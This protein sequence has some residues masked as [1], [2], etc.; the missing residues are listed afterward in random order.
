MIFLK[1][2][3]I[4]CKNS[5]TS[6]LQSFIYSFSIFS[7]IFIE[8][9]NSVVLDIFCNSIYSPKINIFKGRNFVNSSI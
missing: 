2:L 9:C 8:I 1:N 5:N 3:G 7:I 4:C 6:Y